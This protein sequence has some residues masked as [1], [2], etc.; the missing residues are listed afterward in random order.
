MPGFSNATATVAITSGNQNV[1]SL[2]LQP[3]NNQPGHKTPASSSM[4]GVVSSETVRD[5]P[6]NGRDWTQ[7]ATLQAG[8]SS[9]RTQPDATNTS[10]GRGQ[11]GFGAQISVSGGRPQQ[12]N[13]LLDGISIPI[14]RLRLTWRS[15]L[16]PMAEFC[17]RATRG[18]SHFQ[19]NRSRERITSRP[20]W[21]E[22]SVSTTIS[23]VPTSSTL[24]R[25]SNPI[26]STPN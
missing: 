1:V 4:G 6:V 20:D 11:R 8:V 14:R 19:V 16:Y 25:Q 5:M 12:N 24:Q 21:I 17:L 10:S 2:T 23:L 18:S 9:V 22:N 7:A 3:A 13:Y 15:I 26:N